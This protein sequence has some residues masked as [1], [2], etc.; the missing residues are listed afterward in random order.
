V[1]PGIEAPR[2]NDALEQ[3]VVSFVDIQTA[4]HWLRKYPITDLASAPLDFSTAAWYCTI[5]MVA[6]TP[7]IMMTII[8]SISVNPFF[9]A[10]S[11]LLG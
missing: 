9:M 3:S 2:P 11:F 1:A 7:M 4:A 5:P 6:R 10:C 8:N